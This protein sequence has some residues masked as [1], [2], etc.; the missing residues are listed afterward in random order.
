MVALSFSISSLTVIGMLAVITY[1]VSL[2][3]HQYNQ[4]NQYNAYLQT[5]VKTAPLY[6]V[7]CKRVREKKNGIVQI[8]FPLSLNNMVILFKMHK[9]FKMNTDK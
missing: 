2:F 5:H 9:T 7:P 4:S 3:R 8:F 6:F 1:T